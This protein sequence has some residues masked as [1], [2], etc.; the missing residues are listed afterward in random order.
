M[1]VELAREPT[2]HLTQASKDPGRHVAETCP[3]LGLATGTHFLL[4][5]SKCPDG[6]CGNRYCWKGNNPLRMNLPGRQMNNLSQTF[7]TSTVQRGKL[8]QEQ[9]GSPA[10]TTVRVWGSGSQSSLCCGPLV[11]FLV[12][13]WPPQPQ[14]YFIAIITDFAVN[15]K[16]LRCRI[17]DV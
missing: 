12:L 15:F 9:D 8:S 14:N 10:N 1:R 4:T 6:C 13:W 7:I 16:C 11:Q 17:T 5:L 2:L 3:A